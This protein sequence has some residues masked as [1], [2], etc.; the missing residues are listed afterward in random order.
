MSVDEIKIYSVKFFENVFLDI[1]IYTLNNNYMS[2]CYKYNRIYSFS[3]HSNS[4]LAFDIYITVNN[5]LA[6]FNIQ[7]RVRIV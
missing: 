6:V 4:C 3:Y 2:R 7:T 1:R 5:N